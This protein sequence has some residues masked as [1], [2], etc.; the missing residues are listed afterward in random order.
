MLGWRAPHVL[1]TF[2]NSLFLLKSFLWIPFVLKRFRKTQ[3]F[4]VG[5]M[6]TGIRNHRGERASNNTNHVL[7]SIFLA[8][9]VVFALQPDG[10][11]FPSRHE[12]SELLYLKNQPDWEIILKFL[13][14]APVYLNTKTLVSHLESTQFASPCLHS[15]RHL[16]SNRMTW[17]KISVSRLFTW[18][19]WISL[20]DSSCFCDRTWEKTKSGY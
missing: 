5:F 14:F 4:F 10:T 8:F 1:Q 20:I 2:F 6:T 19:K 3:P 17:P 15:N 7:R 13:E 18:T 11:T 16:W 12:T 9:W